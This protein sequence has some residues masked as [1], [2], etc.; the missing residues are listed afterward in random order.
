MLSR[1]ACEALSGWELRGNVTQ[2]NALLTAALIANEGKPTLSA[3]RLCDVALAAK[4][5][6]PP[7]AEAQTPNTEFFSGEMTLERLN[8]KMYFDALRKCRGNTAATARRLG[9]SRAQ[10][11]YR[12]RKAGDGSSRVGE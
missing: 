12:L 7:G 9:L 6:F 2:L 5:D 10:L 4:P 11:A 8:A 3:E 1:D